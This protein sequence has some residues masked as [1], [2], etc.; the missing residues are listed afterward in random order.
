MNASS[1]PVEKK[2]NDL[3]KKQGSRPKNQTVGFRQELFSGQR[4]TMQPFALGQSQKGKAAL[5]KRKTKVVGVMRELLND[6]C[7]ERLNW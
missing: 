5:G 3:N 4:K 2:Q 1:P 6:S 7:W